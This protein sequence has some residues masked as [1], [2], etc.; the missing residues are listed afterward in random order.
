MR[1]KVF[2]NIDVKWGVRYVLQAHVLACSFIN[3]CFCLFA[4]YFVNLF[5]YLF[6]R[7][8]VGLFVCVF[9]YFVSLP[10]RLV[11]SLCL[12]IVGMFRFFARLFLFVS[13]LNCLYI[14][15]LLFPYLFVCLFFVCS[16]V[17]LLIFVDNMCISCRPSNSSCFSVLFCFQLQLQC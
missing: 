10:L 14:C 12:F 17:Y 2:A 7:L 6:T 9:G 13:S 3:T 16:F 4:V 5:I 11:A 1:Y 8:L 15:S